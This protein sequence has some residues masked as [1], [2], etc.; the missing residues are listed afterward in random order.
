MAA[1]ARPR[2][3][4]APRNDAC[5]QP[6]RAT[7]QGGTRKG[8]R[9]R[10][11]AH[12]DG[13]A[14]GDVAKRTRSSLLGGRL[15][16]ALLGRLLLRRL[17]GLLRHFA[18]WERRGLLGWLRGRGRA[19]WLRPATMPA[20]NLNAR[21]LGVHTEG[22]ALACGR[23]RGWVPPTN[24]RAWAHAGRWEANAEFTSWRRTSSC[25]SWRAPP[26]PAPSWPSSPFCGGLRWRG[27][28]NELCHARGVAAPR[29]QH[30][31]IFKIGFFRFRDFGP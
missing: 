30:W 29:D 12:A 8:G 10:A 27:G 21:S 18:G 4:A 11:G 5:A 24:W 23:A 1:G 20:R 25:P 19:A 2:G 16:L 3:V 14:A 22:R 6:Q 17:L 31:E 9:G 7:R 26:P 15:L 13:S 28:R